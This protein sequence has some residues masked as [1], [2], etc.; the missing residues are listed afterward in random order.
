M[1]LVTIV[2]KHTVTRHIMEHIG[3]VCRKGIG[4]MTEN[5]ICGQRCLWQRITKRPELQVTAALLQQW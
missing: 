4:R 2:N 3:K 5:Y 1:A